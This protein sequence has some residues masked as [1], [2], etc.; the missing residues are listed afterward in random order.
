MR[1]ILTILLFLV[2][3]S[4][5][6]ANT[7]SYENGHYQKLSQTSNKGSPAEFNLLSYQIDSKFRPKILFG[8]YSRKETI[9]FTGIDIGFVTGNENFVEGNFGLVLL[10]KPTERLS[11]Q[12]QFHA[13]LHYVSKIDNNF[14]LKYGC[15]HLSNGSKVIGSP[16]PNHAE[17]FCSIGIDYRY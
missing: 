5:S 6:M 15:H 9:K 11:T 8:Q 14:Y 3:V 16:E 2:F 4:S 17:E 1:F 13:S 7:I 10:E 12:L